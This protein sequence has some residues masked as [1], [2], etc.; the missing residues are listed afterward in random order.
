MATP[1]TAPRKGHPLPKPGN[2]ASA[3]GTIRV[4]VP[5]QP[6]YSRE[7]GAAR[8]CANPP[9]DCICSEAQAVE[10]PGL[11]CSGRCGHCNHHPCQL[12]GG[13]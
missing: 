8:A 2:A 11:P 5:I 10:T 13:I 4:A 6:L 1:G 9:P 3:A 7:D 12:H